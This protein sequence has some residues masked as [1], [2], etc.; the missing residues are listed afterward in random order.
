M[1]KFYAQ[2]A[3][4]NYTYYAFHDVGIFDA[5]QLPTLYTLDGLVFI[6]Q[7]ATRYRFFLEDGCYNMYLL[8]VSCILTLFYVAEQKP[9]RPLHIFL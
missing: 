9:S 6:V 4:K 8:I 3:P 2:N 7:D 5:G 1:L